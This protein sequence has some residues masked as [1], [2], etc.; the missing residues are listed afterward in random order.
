MQMKV[1][2]IE[3]YVW[4]AA[5]GI[6]G[7]VDLVIRSKRGAMTCGEEVNLP[8]ELKTGKWK[9]SIVTGHRAQV[10]GF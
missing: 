10:R 6:K 2:G 3:E 1:V 5:L 8:I 9:P 4:C 7:Q